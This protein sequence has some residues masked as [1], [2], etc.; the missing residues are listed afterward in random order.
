MNVLDDLAKVLDELIK[1]AREDISAA[2]N[3]QSNELADLNLKQL[4]E[5]KKATG[6]SMPEYV[7]SSKSPSAPGKIRLK[8]TSNFQKAFY[9]FATPKEITFDSSD[10]KADIL[11]TRK[12]YN[13]VFGL[14]DQRKG[15]AQEL[16]NEQYVK[17]INNK[18]GI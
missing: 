3:E 8:D 2:A 17:D 6:V 18:L 14:D 10:K 13:P 5:G 4:N 11:N 16:I 9:T 1:E 12:D 7:D 15:E